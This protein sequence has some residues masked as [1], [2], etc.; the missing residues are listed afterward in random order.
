MS[1]V[2]LLTGRVQT[3]RLSLIGAAMSVRIDAAGQVN[4]LAGASEPASP[5]TTSSIGVLAAAA[6]ANGD[7]PPTRAYRRRRSRSRPI[8]SRPCSPGSTVSTSLGLD[9]GTLSEIGLK[10]CTLVVDDQR[11]GKRLT[12]ERINLSLTRPQEGGVAFAVNSTGAGGL[13][14]LTATVT[15]KP[16]GRRTIETVIRDVSPKDLMLALRAGDGHFDANVP[17]SAVIRAEIERDGTLQSME[18]RILAGAGYFGSRDDAESRVHIDE[19]QLVLRWNP[20]TRQLQ[21]PFDAQS[22]PSRVNLLAQLDVPAEAG[23]PWTLSIPRGLVVFASADR[24]RDPPLI[25][26]RVSVRARI[27]PDKRLFEIDQADLGGMAGGFAISGAIDYSTPDPRIALGIAGTRMTRVGVQAAV[28]RDGHAA[29][30]LLGGRPRHRRHGGAPRDR[31]QC[32]ALDASSRAARRCPTMACRS[33]SSPAAIR[34]SIV[35]GLPPLRD[36]DLN[37]RVQ[38][39]TATV[40]VARAGSICLRAAS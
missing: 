34:C 40:R 2:S 8:R 21:M 1:A 31:H 24:S 3:D 7:E 35:D 37:V 22:G 6:A 20:A 32:A 25:I 18:G 4:L 33:I 36:A 29:A 16:D 30:A 17:L 10:D 23:A 14:S 15:P 27:D 26:D 28:A 39:R 5:V 11:Y 12:F 19:A 9:G 13:W 38:G